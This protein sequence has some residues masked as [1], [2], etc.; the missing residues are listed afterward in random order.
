MKP[1]SFR[2]VKNTFKISMIKILKTQFRSKKPLN[3]KILIRSYTFTHSI[4]LVINPNVIKKRLAL[5]NLVCTTGLLARNVS[6]SSGCTTTRR[7]SPR[8]TSSTPARP[9]STSY[10]S[11][12]YSPRMP[13][14]DNLL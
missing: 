4:T 6:T 8:R 14:S 1:N 7:S 13:V 12:R 11:P 2:V 10:T 9:T 5:T 3:M